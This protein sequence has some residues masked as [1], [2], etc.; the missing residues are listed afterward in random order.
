MKR[1]VILQISGLHC[2]MCVTTVERAL[3]KL[4]SVSAKIN[5]NKEN[6]EIEFDET[7]I[8]LEKIK[9][10]IKNST[11]WDKEITVDK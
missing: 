11:I 9:D 1:K 8:T 6:A 2:N 4:D 3:N 10:V 7:K 5:F